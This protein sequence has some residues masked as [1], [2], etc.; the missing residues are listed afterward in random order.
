MSVFS[1][2]VTNRKIFTMLEQLKQQNEEL[3]AQVHNQ[4]ALLQLLVGRFG[5]AEEAAAQ[6]PDT[7]ILPST[8]LDQLQDLEAQLSDRALR[9]NVVCNS[10]SC[11]NVSCSCLMNVL[12]RIKNIA[13]HAES[14]HHTSLQLMRQQ[15]ADF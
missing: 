7:L 4:T 10:S 12:G 13:T 2:V 8:S 11:I 9:T 14:V 15:T 3:R 6:L 1:E 5:G